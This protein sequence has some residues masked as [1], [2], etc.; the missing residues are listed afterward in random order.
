MNSYSLTTLPNGLRVVTVPM[1][2]RDSAGVAIWVK[3][4]ARYESMKVSGVSH[5]LE[6][7]LFKGTKT[8]TTR[9]IKEEI[10]GVGGVLNAFTGEESTCYFAKL[11]VRHFPRALDVL[12]DM[13]NNATLSDTEM[14][15]ERTVI[16]EEIKMYKDLPSHHVHDMMGELMWPNEA[17]GRPI[18]GTDES[19]KAL[20]RSQMAAYKKSYYHP[21]NIVV[22]VSGTVEP[23]IIVRHVEERF[24]QK[25][26]LPEA[27]FEK[28]RVK[29]AKPRAAFCEK[30]TEQ[31][32]FVIGLRGLSRF[33]PDRYILGILNVILGS[34]MSS[35]L[36]EEVREKRGLAYE[37]RSGSSFYH[38]TGMLSVSAGV[39]KSKAPKALQVILRELEK[40]RNAL[41][42]ESELRRAK[43][44]FMSQLYM[45]IEDTLEHLLWAGERVLDGGEPPDHDK[46]RRSIEAVTR[47]DIQK[48]ARRLFV[49][50]GL[51]LALIG[52]LGKKVQDT[53]K[54]DFYL[55]EK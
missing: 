40:F 43:D 1:T 52:P 2:G 13:V 11:L 34:N 53:I 37:I 15:K 36:F 47:E 5:F 10:E 33:H 18:S 14:R 19:V 50:Q 51:N 3:T 31:T 46:I 28:I 54:Q 6:H 9:Q 21:R 48:V 12:S 23:D 17:L 30:Q 41:V 32:H 4:G 55:K 24:N 45:A 35:R 25:S 42:S 27:S 7:M 22:S 16:L 26:P 29:Q 20:T 38:D 44:Y 49:N 39:E 8:R